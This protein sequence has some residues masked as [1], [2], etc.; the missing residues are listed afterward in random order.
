[1][2]FGLYIRYKET[3][4]SIASSTNQVPYILRIITGNHQVERQFHLAILFRI[5]FQLDTFG[6]RGHVDTVQIIGYR[7]GLAQPRQI[8]IVV[9]ARAKCI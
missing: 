2:P 7:T 5:N 9:I 1:M 6:F 8:V 3:L 4:T